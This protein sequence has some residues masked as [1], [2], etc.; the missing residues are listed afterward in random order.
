[1]M[2]PPTP[3]EHALLSRAIGLHQAG[4]IAGARPV[5]REVL[6]LRPEDPEL[7]RL[8]GT[9]E[10]QWGDHGGAIELL[11]KSLA[12]APGQPG[13]LYNRG[14]ALQ[15]AGRIDEAVADYDETLRLKPDFAAAYVNRGNA[16]TDLRRYEEAVASFDRAL[17]LQPRDPATYANRAVALVA[18]DKLEAAAACYHKALALD[19]A[20]APAHSGL[21]AVYE[22][23][24]DHKRAVVQWSRMAEQVSGGTGNDPAATVFALNNMTRILADAL[25]DDVSTETV[26]RQ[27]LRIDPRQPEAAQ[28]LIN[29]RMRRCAWPIVE[30]FEGVTR[31]DIL[32]G[33]SPLA[34]AAYTD[35]PL[36][37]LAVNWRR[38]PAVTDATPLH[39]PKDE[40][41]GGRLRVGYLSSD[42][43]QHPGGY[44]MH[45]IPGLH[46]RTKVEA[47]AYYTGPKTTDPVHQHYRAAFEHFVDLVDL[48][49]AEAARRIAD[50]GIQILIDVNGHTVHSRKGVL[51]RRPA[52]VIVNWLGFPGSMGG[53][54]HHYLLA[55]D[56]T[57]PAQNEI[58]FSEKVLRLPCYQPNNRLRAVSPRAPDRAAAGLPRDAFVFCCFNDTKKI[59]R[60]TFD[61]WLTILERTPGSVL[62]LLAVSKATEASLREHAAARGVEPSRL[63][64]APWKANPDHLA[65]YPLAD[66]FLDTTPYGAHTTCSDALWMGVPVL[67]VSGRSF[68]SRV[69]GSLLRQAGLEDLVLGDLHSFVETAVALAGDPQRLGAYRKRLSGVRENSVLFDTPTLVSSLEAR[70]EEMWR[71]CLEDALPTP[72]LRNMEAYLAVGL[73]HDHEAEEVQAIEDYEGFWRERL[74][75]YAKTHPLD[76]DSRLCAPT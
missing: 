8:A 33:L 52:P 9:A 39:R 69:C 71:A 56:W 59:T 31:E 67:T 35:D 5:Y 60:H 32:A 16:L 43:R 17:A 44:L 41:T 49:D 29:A 25:L 23:Q 14:L 3:Q 47:F 55:D 15:A 11:A 65:R 51:A 62:W 34:A 75:K 12:L 13:T 36:F 61:R 48:D 2:R 46:D 4:D 38:A 21:A 73:S 27:S 10:L 40:L 54:V 70:F 58:F 28:D 50:D 53:P 72:D 74:A 1:M 37:Q 24:G 22:R 76:S 66:L 30:P 63:V 64:F 68:A 19:P 42:L 57:V 7:L 26:A 45:E 18:L 20:F 6:A